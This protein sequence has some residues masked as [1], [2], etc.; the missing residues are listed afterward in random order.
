[1]DDTTYKSIKSIPDTGIISDVSAQGVGSYEISDSLP[2]LKMYIGVLGLMKDLSSSGMKCFLYVLEYLPKGLDF[3]VIDIDTL[4]LYS[5]YKYKKNTM[6]GVVELINIGIL[7][8]KGKNEY[9]VNPN[10]VFKGNRKVLL[11]MDNRSSLLRSLLMGVKERRELL[12]ANK[13]KNDE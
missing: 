7:S 1:M 8:R 11:D 10:Y 13:K 3:M 5:G 9:W 12:I 4:H 2:Y 6:Q